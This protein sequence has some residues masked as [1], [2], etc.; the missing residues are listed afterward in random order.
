MGEIR[1][2][3]DEDGQEGRPGLLGQV[4]GAHGH[5]DRVR[6][7]GCDRLL[8]LPVLVGQEGHRL[9]PA[10]G[11]EGRPQG[12]R[13]GVRQGPDPAHG[14]VLH[15]EALEGPLR[16]GLDDDRQGKEARER[17]AQQLPVAEVS[18]DE[19]HALAAREGLV[20]VPAIRPGDDGVEL[21][22]AQDRKA[23]QLHDG[24][25]QLAQVG[26]PQVHGLDRRHGGEGRAD[27]ALDEAP[28]GSEAI[29]PVQAVGESSPRRH[30]ACATEPASERRQSLHE[31]VNGPVDEV[32]GPSP[33]GHLTPRL[34][35]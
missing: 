4:E 35:V 21:R 10:Q 18:R 5:R 9:A 15:E 34:A 14:P 1:S 2:A 31:L 24:P 30:G 23:H 11:P 22:V 20:Q 3:G 19:D 17:R 33:E 29:D 26:A 32:H 27:V 25:Q 12:G 16:G 13:P 7:E 8:G 28:V 6:E